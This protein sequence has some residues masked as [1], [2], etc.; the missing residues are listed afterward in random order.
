MNPPEKRYKNRILAALPEGELDRLTPYLS[1]VT[2]K[3]GTELLNG[4]ADHAY[5]LEGGL[6]SAVLTLSGGV[7]VEVGVVGI[8]GV[9]GLPVLLGAERVPGSTFIQV[10]GS[11][12]QIE[13]DRFSFQLTQTGGTPC[14]P[15]SGKRGPARA[16]ES[17]PAQAEV[18]RGTLGSVEKGNR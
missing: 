4:H 5:F 13:A 7:T 10:E 8:D 2:L 6:A 17:T 14:L 12:F 16:C 11:G 1:P 15:V 3:V 18:E 9:V